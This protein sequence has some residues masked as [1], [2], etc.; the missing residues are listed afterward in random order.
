[1]THQME[2]EYFSWLKTVDHTMFT[3]LS[4]NMLGGEVEGKQL[5]I[6]KN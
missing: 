3:N 4:L 6:I 1:M 2:K 5:P